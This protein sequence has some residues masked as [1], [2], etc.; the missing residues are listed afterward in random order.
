[1]REERVCL[2]FKRNTRATAFVLQ[3]KLVD[4]ACG[5]SCWRARRNDS[6]SILN[7]RSQRIRKIS[8]VLE[9]FGPLLLRD[10]FP[11]FACLCRSRT[12]A[13]NSRHLPHLL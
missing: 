13:G 4:A 11:L 7:P 8:G 12:Q 2:C 10:I 6:C 5:P 9:L 1:M 3:R